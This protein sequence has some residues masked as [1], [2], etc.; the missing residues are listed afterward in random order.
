MYYGNH[1]LVPQSEVRVI[2]LGIKGSGKTSIVQRFRELEDGQ[3]HYKKEGWTE[4]ISINHIRCGEDGI[5]HVW[6]FGGQEIMLSTHTLFLRDHCIYIIVLNARQGDE[7]ERWLDYISQ[8]GRNST[9]FIVDNHMDEAD[10]FR[11]D[12]NKMRRMYPN[13]LDESSKI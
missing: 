10:N 12:I 2:L 1:A 9:V 7:P 3:K 11:P 5:L 8:Y 4:G 13:L 6:D